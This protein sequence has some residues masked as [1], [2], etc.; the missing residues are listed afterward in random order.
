[1]TMGPEPTMRIESMS[2]RFGMAMGSLAVVRRS[3]WQKYEGV[4]SWEPTTRRGGAS[5]PQHHPYMGC[6]CHL[7]GDPQ[8]PRWQWCTEPFG[9]MLG[10]TNAGSGPALMKP[11]NPR[12]NPGEFSNCSAPPGVHSSEGLATQR[13]DVRNPTAGN[14]QDQGLGNRIQK[15]SHLGS[16]SPHPGRSRNAPA[17]LVRAG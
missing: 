11:R 16:H 14:R 6:S 7:I 10:S 4:R 2:V 3:P 13:V 12:R 17:G 5:P 8:L 1:M 9:A 15:R